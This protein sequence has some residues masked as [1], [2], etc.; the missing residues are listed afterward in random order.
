MFSYFLFVF[1][2]GLVCSGDI[3]LLY[4][5][6]KPWRPACCSHKQTPETRIFI[7]STFII[8]I[9]IIHLCHHHHHHHHLDNDLSTNVAISSDIKQIE[10]SFDESGQRF[11][12]FKLFSIID[13][14]HQLTFLVWR[15][16]RGGSSSQHRREAL[17]PQLWTNQSE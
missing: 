9:N 16:E 1:K 15:G 10:G 12:H 13:S 3:R 4:F 8:I 5:G 6:F 17:A 11:L 2:L 7:N 14:Q